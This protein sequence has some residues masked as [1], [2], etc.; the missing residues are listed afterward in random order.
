MNL[1]SQRIFVI[2]PGKEAA[3]SLSD[4]VDQLFENQK[5]TWKQFAEAL[6]ALNAT[7]TRQINCDAIPVTLQFNPRRI[8]STGAR[9]DEQSLQSRE[10]FLCI[11]NLPD[12]QR[13]ILYQDKFLILCNPAPIFDR[14]IT[15][16]H[17][18]H[19]EQA[20]EPF[21]GE[22]LDLAQDLSPSFTVFYNGPKCGA[23]A[24]DH[25]HFQ[26]CPSDVLPIKHL[27]SQEEKK[28]LRM[29]EKEFSVWT[30]KNCGRTLIVV[31]STNKQD[32]EKILRR[33]LAAMRTVQEKS[34]EPMINILCSFGN[35]MWEM[36]IFPRTKH[37]PDV[38][39]NEGNDRILISPG[40]VD[41]AGFV[42]TPVE[43][44]FAS[45]DARLIEQIYSEVCLDS[46]SFNQI[47]N[48]L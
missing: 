24:P 42:V 38:Y 9:L 45:V 2:H 31:R 3:V 43:K 13:G 28:E 33:L 36:I 19:V 17:V 6:E 12:E 30:L 37:R 46:S 14:H 32:A 48:A 7:K 16:S 25:M 39:Y 21:T 35:G 8:T 26:A 18:H 22:L 41:L 10:C 47:F 27:G 34:D 20:I 15:I 4:R 29:K 23:S 5:S 44:D 40:A 11:Q 1:T